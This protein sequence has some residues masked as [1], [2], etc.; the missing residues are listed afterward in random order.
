MKDR[1]PDVIYTECERCR[2]RAYLSRKMARI[3]RSR[4]R[5]DPGH[6]NAYPCPRLPGYWHLGNLSPDVISGTTARDDYYN[7]PHRYRPQD[8]LIT[9]T[10]EA[11]MTD[12]NTLNS[13]DIN[14]VIGKL[15]GNGHHPSDIAEAI[16]GGLLSDLTTYRFVPQ[17]P[18]SPALARRILELNADNQRNHRQSL[19][20]RYARDMSTGRW[21]EKSGQPINI[22]T[23]GRVINGQHRLQGVIKAGKAIKFD[24]NMGIDPRAIV[25]IDAGPGRSAVDVIR[26][27]GGSDL[28]GIA[29]IVRWVLMWEMGTPTGRGGRFA[30][31]P[32]ELLQRYEADSDLFNTA[33]A[34]GGDVYARGLAS[35]A[36]G[37][38]AY[39]LFAKMNQDIAN[40]LF[41][42][43]VSGLNMQGGDRGAAWHLRTRLFA[44]ASAKLARHE[45]L[46]LF[47]RAWNLYNTIKNDQRV[48]V[49][50]LYV[51][52]D[53]PLTNDNF[54]RVR[55]PALP[56]S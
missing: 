20:D 48:P 45:R 30:P 29:A 15:V 52:S 17:V 33:A 23:N 54:P 24:I 39:F 13:D 12:L 16:L 25:V 22:A 55:Q 18:V 28:S 50:T 51:S 56:K 8:D 7:L 14:T 19:S 1:G 35:K 2:K 11:P 36:V 6:L 3:A 31:T 5:G 32:Q 21:T 40:D 34:R 41:D 38:T 27:S 49:S 10:W 53:G 43:I 26:T 9:P 44:P 46:S 4:M 47:I 37:G 42:Q